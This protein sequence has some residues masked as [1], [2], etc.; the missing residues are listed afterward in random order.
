MLLPADTVYGSADRDADPQFSPD[1]GGTERALLDQ[2][3]LDWEAMGDYRE[4]R[5]RMRDLRRGRH[6]N[7]LMAMDD[8]EGRAWRVLTEE[9]WARGR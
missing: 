4:R 9:F 2:C 5:R 1:E 8:N 6:W 3:R 7:R